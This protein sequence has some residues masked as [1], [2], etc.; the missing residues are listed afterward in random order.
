MF[1]EFVE[2]QVAGHGEDR[3][4]DSY[5]AGSKASLLFHFVR[6]DAGHGGGIAEDEDVAVAV[7]RVEDFVIGLNPNARSVVQKEVGAAEGDEGRDS[8]EREQNQDEAVLE[9]GFSLLRMKM[10]FGWGGCCGHQVC[11]LVDGNDHEERWSLCL[12][13]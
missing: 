11:S 12:K 13:C 5:I 3:V 9:A 7:A 8:E 2:G 4:G 1:E 6:I 10:R